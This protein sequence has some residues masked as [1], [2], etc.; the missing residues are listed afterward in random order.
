MN[1]PLHEQSINFKIP[2]N[3]IGFFPIKKGNSFMYIL[4]SAFSFKVRLEKSILLFVYSIYVL[5]S[6]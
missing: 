1:L 6:T 4:Q 3:F 2:H 5:L